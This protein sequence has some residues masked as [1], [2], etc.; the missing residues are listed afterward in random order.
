MRTSIDYRY[1]SP[2]TEE[3]QR[4]QTFAASFDHCI[5]PAAHTNVYAHYKGDVLFG[6]SDHVFLPIVYPAFHPKFTSPRDVIQ[7]M[8]DWK[9]HTQL[10]GKPGG[11]GVP[12]NN[13]TATGED[14]PFSEAVMNKLGLIRMNRELYLPK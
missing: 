10:A 6:Y 4:L 7:V 1:V 3:F 11:I 8:A 5:A 2:N 13:K 12:L 9:T 14:L